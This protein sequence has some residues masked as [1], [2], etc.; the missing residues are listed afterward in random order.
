MRFDGT[1]RRTHLAVTGKTGLFAR[2]SPNRPSEIVLSPD[3]R[4]VLARVT[5]QLYLLA[6]PAVRRRGAQGLGAR[7]V[8]PAQEAHRH[9]RRLRRLGRRRQDDHLGHRRQLLPPAVRFGRLPAAQE[10]R[11][12]QG[13]TKRK[14]KPKRRHEKPKPEEIAVVI[15]QPQAP[16]ARDGRPQRGQGHHDARR[17]GD[18]RGRHR[19]DRPP[20]RGR[21]ARRVRSRSPR[22]PRS[23]TSTGKTI[24]PGL[25]RHPRPLDGDPPRGARH[26]EL[27]L[28]RQPRLRRDHRPRPADRHQ[29]HVRLPGPRRDRRAGRPACLLDRAGRLLR[30]RF[31]VG[32][33]RRGGGRP[34]Q[35]VLPHEHAEIVHD[36]QPPPAPV[37]DR[38]LPQERGHADHRGGPRP[39]AEPDARARRLQRQRAQPAGGPALRRRGRAVRADGDLVH[40]DAAGR[41]R[42][43]VRR[44]RFL[45]DDVDSR[46]PEDP[47]VHPARDPRRQGQA[48]GV[49]S[50]ERACLSR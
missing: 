20:D 9:R 2:A 17:R 30:Q 34:V 40:A 48:L 15:E 27:E 18:R 5:N 8:R 43:P 42:R 7:A 16:P 44:D 45:H 3:G 4:W 37:D 29:R 1:D 25:R 10:R 28:L 22:G 13:R 47:P 14:P 26:A 49:V 36:R 23:S 46:R 33:G 41:L 31:P 24:V 21:R 12:R 35:E 6:L 19:R 32:R 11:R 38:G 39:E 50:Q